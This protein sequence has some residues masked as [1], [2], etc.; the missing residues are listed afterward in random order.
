MI[1]LEYICPPS[2]S[3]NFFLFLIIYMSNWQET[4]IGYQFSWTLFFLMS[5]CSCLIKKKKIGF[6][7]S[8][9]ETAM[10]SF[11]REKSNLFVNENIDCK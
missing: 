10:L 5:V 11:E 9:F 3:C 7:G 8:E 4:R 1:D 6:R 2:F